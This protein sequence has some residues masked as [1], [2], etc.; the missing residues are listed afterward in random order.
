MSG[1]S[2]ST[3]S[4][5]DLSLNP[6]P[7]LGGA[8]FRDQRLERHRVLGRVLEPGEE[9]EGFT[10]IARMVKTT[11]NGREPR[12]PKCDVMRSLFKHESPLVLRE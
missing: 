1:S 3:E 10:D 4:Y 12:E 11:G 5:I 2:C 9:I 6:S 7:F 8:H